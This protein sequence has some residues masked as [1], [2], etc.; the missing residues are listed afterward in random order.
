MN[1]IGQNKHRQAFFLTGFNNW[2]K[3][4][5]IFKLFNRNRFY[6]GHTY[7]INGL[8]INTK[9]TVEYHSNDDFWGESWVDQINQRITHAPDNAKN[10]IT[11]LCPTLHEGNNFVELLSNVQKSEV[12]ITFRR[13]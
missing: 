3:S 10:L 7:P 11:A 1:Y 12:L 2:G 9:F 8:N 5:L 6:F 4:I 13:K